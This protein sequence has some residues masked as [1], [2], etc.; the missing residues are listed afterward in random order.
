MDKILT[1]ENGE[2]KINPEVLAEL[3]QV[4]L[5]KANADKR[6]KELTSA[7]LKECAEDYYNAITKISDYNLV[8]K[9]GTYTLEFDVER[10]K[11][12]N[13]LEYANYCKVVKTEESCSL[14]YA[15]RG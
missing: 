4:R 13:P 9:G 11:L 8:V 14:T 7:I 12:E 5:I 1:L 3:N 10:F 2:L 6:Y 15:K